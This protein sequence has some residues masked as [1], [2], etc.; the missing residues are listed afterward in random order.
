MPCR[1]FQFFIFGV[2]RKRNDLHAIQQRR[3]H[4]IAVRRGQEH[5]VREIIFNLQIVIHKC[6][7][8]F[9]VENLQ[10]RTGRIPTEILPHLVDLIEQDQRIGGFRL[11]HRLNDLARHRP[12]IGAAMAPNFGLV[13][14]TAQTDANKLAPRGLRHRFP[15]R[16]FPNTRRA[17]KTKDRPLHLGRTCL[18]REIFDNALFDLLKPVMIRIQNLFGA[19]EVLFH[20]AFHA[21]RQRDDPIEIIAHHSRLSGHG[22]H[23]F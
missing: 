1:N 20:T 10:H 11:F 5:H 14:H 21:P 17:H 7:V 6:G 13:P 22:R 4:V 23:I 12:D 8:L 15:K 18:H 3:R 16:G 2:A 9:R 19:G